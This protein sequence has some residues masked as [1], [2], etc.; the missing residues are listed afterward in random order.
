MIRLE[1][2]PQGLA[3]NHVCV[4]IH[5]QEPNCLLFHHISTR[6]PWGLS[7][8]LLQSLNIG[9]ANRLVGVKDF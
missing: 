5:P 8:R 6:D 7:L 2:S 9:F 4:I 1:S 3:G